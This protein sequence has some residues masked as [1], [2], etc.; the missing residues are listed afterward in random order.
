MEERAKRR[1]C[2]RRKDEGDEN[3]N[4]MGTKA[5]RQW[6]ETVGN[7]G[8]VYWMPRL[9]MNCSAREGE[10]RRGGE[11]RLQYIVKYSATQS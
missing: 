9:T 1:P 4:I 2:N 10:G 3:L 11:D 6:S 5:G 8:R 7:G